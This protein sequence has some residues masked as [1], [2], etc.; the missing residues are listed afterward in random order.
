MFHSHLACCSILLS[1]V[2]DSLALSTLAQSCHHLL[3]ALGGLPITPCSSC[4]YGTY[5][6]LCDQGPGYVLNSSPATDSL[7]KQASPCL[8]SYTCCCSHLS[9]LDILIAFLTAVTACSNITPSMHFPTPI[10]SYHTVLPSAS[11]FWSVVFLTSLYQITRI[12]LFIASLSHQDGSSLRVEALP[13]E[14]TIE[15]PVP[16]T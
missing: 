14:F 12:H 4:E 13:V 1:M 16:R 2:P 5:K 6:P 7:A 10:P 3:R 9:T 11:F 8:R 15:V